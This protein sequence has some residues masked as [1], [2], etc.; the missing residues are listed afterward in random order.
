MRKS[1]RVL[2]TSSVC[3]VYEILGE[4]I[5]LFLIGFR[6]C[7]YTLKSRQDIYHLHLPHEE[8]ET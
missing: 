7:K 6:M 2:L 5:F 3:V 1:L 4:K 8:I